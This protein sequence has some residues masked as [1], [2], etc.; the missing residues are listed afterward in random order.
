MEHKKD[1]RLLRK[2]DLEAAKKGEIV[3]WYDTAETLQYIGPSTTFSEAGCFKWLSGETVAGTYEGYKAEQL[4]MAPLAWVEGKPV[5][6]GDVLYHYYVQGHKNR[7][8]TVSDT[9]TDRIGNYLTFT[10]GGNWAIDGSASKLS[11]NNPKV[12]KSGWMNC[13]EHNE[14]S[15]Y[16]TKARADLYALSS[17]TACIEI[18]WEE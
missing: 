13:Y 10:E 4:R 15:V 9:F 1:Y 18:F 17:R 12:K 14:N 2:F 3:Q 16:P 11:W 8:V 7:L 5:Y 6:K